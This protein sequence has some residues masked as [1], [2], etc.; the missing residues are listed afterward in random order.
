MA[1]PNNL[2]KRR[3]LQLEIC[4]LEDRKSDL[5]RQI[6]HVETL[7]MAKRDE[8]NQLFRETIASELAGME[9]AKDKAIPVDV[10][11]CFLDL[12][13]GM[14]SDVTIHA[15]H[16]QSN[17]TLCGS[18]SARMRD[19]GKNSISQV[20]CPGCNEAISKWNEGF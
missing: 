7:I 9:G 3:L 20:N 13:R 8:T 5:K 16:G 4:D 1:S 2:L 11:P 10:V 18:N 19:F 15:R 6:N 12:G 17:L 14:T